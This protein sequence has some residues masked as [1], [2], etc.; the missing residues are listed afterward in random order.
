MNWLTLLVLSS[1]GLIAG[2]A[3]PEAQPSTSRIG[4]LESSLEKEPASQVRR[5]D[6]MRALLDRYRHTGEPALLVSAERH[7]AMALRQDATNFDARKMQ[8]WAALL[9]GRPEQALQLSLMLNKQMPDNVEIY[10]YMVEAYAML[11]KLEQAEQQANWMLRL[12]PENRDSIRCAAE[13]RE[14]F[15]DAEGALQMWNDLYRRTPETLVYDRSFAL[16]RIAQLMKKSNPVR[17]KVVA[18][19]SLRLTPDSMAAKKAVAEVTE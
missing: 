13:L 2:D 8:A 18:A 12:R 1:A 7:I 3:R 14:R 17:A 6:L 5:S 4:L 11:G 16:A 9:G 19:E 10:G 15:G